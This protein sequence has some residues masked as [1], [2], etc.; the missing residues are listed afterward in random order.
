VAHRHG[1]FVSLSSSPVDQE[2]AGGADEG[3]IGR[4]RQW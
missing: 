1:S 2:R 3:V 4:Y